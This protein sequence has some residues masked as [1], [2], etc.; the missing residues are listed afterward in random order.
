MADEDNDIELGNALEG[1]TPEDLGDRKK[2]KFLSD[3]IA[4]V[5]VYVASGIIAVLLTIT[6]SVIT[7]RVLDKGSINRSFAEVSKEYETIPE[8][9][10]YFTMIPQIRGV[11]RDQ[12]PHSIIVKVEIGYKEG[13][14]QVQTELVA[15][16]AQLTDII[17]NYFSQKTAAELAPEREH[18][19]KTELKDLINR[20]LSQGKV[21]DI[22]FPELQVYEF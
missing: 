3:K 18:I 10:I 15:R 16:T 11:T 12:S 22:I 5:L 14:P 1:A 8:P 4:R 7:F 6:I 19:V 17:R 2:K 9:Y 13:E 21:Y 20:V